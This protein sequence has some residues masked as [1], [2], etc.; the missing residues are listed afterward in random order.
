[1]QEVLFLEVE[2]GENQPLS[3]Q[4]VFS[5]VAE[6][7]AVR[8]VRLYDRGVPEGSWYD[9]AGWNADGP[10]GEVAGVLV[11]DSGSGF[12]YLI[13]GGEQGLRLRPSGGAPWD[14]ADREQWG[15]THMVLESESDIEW[16]A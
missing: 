5:A 16:G 14:L 2:E 8:R 13:H 15:Q 9:V 12:A 7:R 3:L 1:M 4:L 10:S 11:E 6:P